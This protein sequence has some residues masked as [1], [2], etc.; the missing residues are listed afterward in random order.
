MRR[1]KAID[2]INQL[3]GSN[4][5]LGVKLKESYD[6][7]VNTLNIDDLNSF[8]ELIYEFRGDIMKGLNG[9]LQMIG[10]FRA[11]SLEEYVYR[12]IKRGVKLTGGLDVYWND[13]VVIWKFDKDVYAIRFDVL[14][15]SKSN[16]YVEPITIVETK[17]EVDAPRLKSVFTNFALVKMLKPNVR[18]LLIYVKWNAA[19]LLKPITLKY[20]D[21]LYWFGAG[22]MDNVNEFVKYL[23]QTIPSIQSCSTGY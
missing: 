4:Y 23:N 12:L 3:M 14:I 21:K 7:W 6:R 11:Y 13:D 17:V 20:A 22:C 5:E 9:L 2:Y 16:R 10:Q 1:K 8:L 19:K 15:G 18:T